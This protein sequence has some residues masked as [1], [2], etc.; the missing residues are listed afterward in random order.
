MRAPWKESKSQAVKVQEVGKDRVDAPNRP[1]C[2]SPAS[3]NEGLRVRRDGLEPLSQYQ[4]VFHCQRHAPEERL[5]EVGGPFQVASPLPHDETGSEEALVIWL[6]LGLALYAG[7]QLCLL[8]L[9]QAAAWADDRTE[10]SRHE[11]TLS[12]EAFGDASADV[13]NP[14]AQ[15]VGW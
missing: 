6:A 11:Y 9:L 7:L 13:D 5:H 12:H 14:D 1:T 2:R 4:R 10:R 8:A 3:R 15:V